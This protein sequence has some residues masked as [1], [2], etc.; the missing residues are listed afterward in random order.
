M[1]GSGKTDRLSGNNTHHWLGIVIPGDRSDRIARSACSAA[2]SFALA[3]DY[4]AAAMNIPFFD[5]ETLRSRQGKKW[6]RYDHDVLPAWVAD[7][8]FPIAEPIK[9]VVYKALEHSDFGYPHLPTAESLAELY[10]ER[11]ERLYGWR[12]V[13]ERIELVTD[14]VQGIYLLLDRFSSPGAGALILT[15]IYPPFL[16]SARRMDR[17]ILNSDL[18][19]DGGTWHMDFDHIRAQAARGARYLMLCN[20]HNP[21][22]RVFTRAELQALAEIA[23][24]F[25]LMVISDEIHADLVFPGHRHIPFAT[26]DEKV[27]KR[28]VT[29]TSASKAFN[30]AGLRSAIAV[31][32]DEALQKE[33]NAPDPHL[34]GAV[35]TFGVACTYAAWSQGDEWLAHVLEVLRHNRDLIGEH[36]RRNAPEIAYTPPQATYLAWLDCRDL[37]LQTDPFTH[38]LERAKVAFNDGLDFGEAGRGFVRLNFATSPEVLTQVL[39]RMV[40]SL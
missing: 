31:F 5:I 18:I 38:F 19:A 39:D 36:L 1:G 11:V 17:T 13:P 30:I 14:V 2:L 22:G 37:R 40:E 9:E 4:T 8:D 20:P 15:P 33:F 35:N 34:R 10:C 27:A 16:A 7:M 24:E 21:T 25:D 23:L 32:G 6:R 3:D 12:V 28:T 29:L 26:L